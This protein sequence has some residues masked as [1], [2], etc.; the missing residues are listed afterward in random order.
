MTGLEPPFYNPG[1]RTMKYYYWANALIGVNPA[2]NCCLF[3]TEA[4]TTIKTITMTPSGIEFS[5]DTG[6]IEIGGTLDTHIFLRGS[7]SASDSGSTGVIGIEPDS[8]TYV[9]SAV[10][11]NNAAMDLK[12]TTY[13]D[14]YGI[15]HCQKTGIAAGSVITITATASYVNPSGSTSTYTDTFTATVI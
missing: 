7:L 12:S 9:L 11:E 14:N 1:N 3:T 2:A 8:A 4:A 6:N 10:D 13:V 5:P 15:L